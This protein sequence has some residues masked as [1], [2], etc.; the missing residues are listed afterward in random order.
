MSLEQAILDAIHKE[1]PVYYEDRGDER[2]EAQLVAVAHGFSEATKHFARIGFTRTEAAAY[3]ITIAKF[4]TNFSLRIQMGNC[5]K[6][7]CDHGLAVGLFQLHESKILPHEEWEG[8]KG[9][10]AEVVEKQAT[11]ALGYI[12][13]GRFACGKDPAQ[14]L[15]NYAGRRCS[16]TDW[17]GL[18]PR[19]AFYNKILRR[20]Q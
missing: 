2:K 10:S 1:V 13:G 9:L 15:T 16:A 14:V 18:A 7:E 12:S 17:A 4:E 6:K 5:R 20:L 11:Y 19:L 3:L 8:L